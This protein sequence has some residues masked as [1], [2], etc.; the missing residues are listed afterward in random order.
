M[1]R[2]P[3]S[4]LPVLVFALGFSAMGWLTSH[5]LAYA[6]VGVEAP[7]AGGHVHG[8][9]AHAGHGYLTA[10]PLPALLTMALG[11]AV[12]LRY[13]FAGGSLTPAL[14]PG[15]ALGLRAQIALATALP[16]LVFVA[17]ELAQNGRGASGL[18]LAVGI[19]LELL[20]GGVV[21]FAIRAALGAVERIVTTLRRPSRIAPA[22]AAVPRPAGVLLAAPG[23]PLARRLAGRAPPA[24]GAL[25]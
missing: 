14:E 6:I 9:A 16:A 22:R 13:L 23:S 17:V 10:L 12:L 3:S 7:T 5:C 18:V 20:V 1:T 21:L 19:V 15:G 8:A 2:R 24:A 25:A 11:V 4:R